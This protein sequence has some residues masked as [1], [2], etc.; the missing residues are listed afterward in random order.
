MLKA[1]FLRDVKAVLLAK[2][3]QQST[4]LKMQQEALQ[5]LKTAVKTACRSAG[6]ESV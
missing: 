4:F 6:R 5:L 2:E 1:I 3:R